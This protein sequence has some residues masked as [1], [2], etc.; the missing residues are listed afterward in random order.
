MS[1][2]FN[3]L[4]VVLPERPLDLPVGVALGHGVA[5]IVELLALA[6]AELQLHATVL[7]VDF[8]RHQRVALPGD[9]AVQLADLA[10]VHEELLGAHGVA[11]EDVALLVGADMHALNPE[12]ALAHLRPRLL[13]V[14]PALP[15][16]LDLGAKELQAA[17][18][19]LLHEIV[20]KGPAILRHHL[21]ALLMRH[22]ATSP[23]LA[24]FHY[25]I[26][27]TALQAANILI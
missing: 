20:M 17:L 22:S 24:F 2:W 6:Q 11:I 9:E 19:A 1:L 21:D 13:E 8:Q 26:V 5:L 7:E 3:R 23:A 16:G 4:L 12:L 14:H 10:A 15:H 27:F 18:I 25:I